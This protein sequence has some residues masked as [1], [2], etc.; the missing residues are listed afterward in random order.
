MIP[1]LEEDF[2]A[3]CLRRALAEPGEPS[4]PDL[5]PEAAAVAVVCHLE[6][7]RPSTLWIRRSENPADPWSGHM[8]F[9]GGRK[10]PSDA[11]C[12]QTAERETA[13]EL[14][15]DLAADAEYL[16]PLRE[17]IVYNRTGKAPFKLAAHVY[18]APGLPPL[19][20]DPREVAATHRIA[21]EYLLDEAHATQTE[22][23]WV[24]KRYRF[25]AIRFGERRIWGLSHRIW[26]DLRARLEAT[27]LLAALG[28][29]G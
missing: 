16:G 25:P 27:E 8:G 10:D 3:R 20:P 28:A 1:P 11:G 29:G 7:G 6:A 26:L 2:V 13:E 5:P 24:K 23:T 9:P 18:W 14:G 12:R 4:A 22:V 19:T 15:L 17:Q 21:M